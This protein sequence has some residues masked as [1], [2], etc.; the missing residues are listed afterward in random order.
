MQR[1]QHLDELVAEAVLERYAAA[2]DPARHEQHLLVLDVDALDQADPLGEVE[3]LRLGERCCRVPAAVALPDHRWVEA[4]LDRRPDRERRREVVALD[5]E[6]RAVADS[7]LVDLGEQLVGRV[8]RE[9]VGGARLDPDP[10]EGEEAL[11]LPGRRA[12]ELV[13]AEL[14]ARE[15]ERPLRM[16]LESVIAMS[17]YVTPASKQASK[18]GTLKSGSTAL[19]TASGRVSRIS[20][21][22][23][24]RLDASIRC[25][26]KRPSSVAATT[27]SGCGQVVVRERSGRR[28]TGARRSTRT[29]SRHRRCRR[30]GSSSMSQRR[31]APTRASRRRA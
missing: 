25:A 13:V 11:L 24:S 8:P 10:D 12:L 30:R 28:T 2:V 21:S 6:V 22:T 3:H 9:H 4:L 20:A 27:A 5:D 31:E 19:S 26:E 17:R 18:I 1:L 15:L 14:D 29:P 16:G 23:L 7:D